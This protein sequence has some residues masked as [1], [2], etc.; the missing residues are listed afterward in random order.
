MT[1]IKKIATLSCVALAGFNA[2]CARI[3]ENETGMKLRNGA[4]AEVITSPKI[5]CFTPC[6]LGTDIIRYKTFNDTFTI[7]SGQGA[8]TTAPSGNQAEASQSRQIFLRSKDDKFIE[9]VSFSIAY[10]VNKVPGITALYTE[11]RADQNTPE[12]NALL[13][14]DDLQI[15]ATQPLVSV[16][17]SYD[18]LNLQDS[19]QEIGNKL[20]DALQ[21]S[22]NERL[23]VKAGEAS[24]ITIKAVTL[25]GVKFDA[26]TE[27]LL[28]KKIYAFEARD[29]ARIA[30]EGAA[31][32]ADGAAAQAAVTGRI[33]SALRAAGTPDNQV[34]TLTCLDMQ[35]QKLIPTTIQCVS[36]FTPGR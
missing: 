28:K 32:Q 25:G 3:S 1:L 6:L 7:S 31:A 4:I 17:R 13:I 12:E 14:R 33:V 29:I 5:V 15:L 22:V 8:A 23:G 26:E 24:P 11:F 19:G 30:G 27:D 18:A 35:R 36:S 20:R 2:A 9:S 16:V 34:G 10:E 21:A